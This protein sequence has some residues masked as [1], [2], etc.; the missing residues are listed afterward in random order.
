MADTI[1]GFPFWT[2]IFDENGSQVKP[3]SVDRLKNDLKS[4]EISELFIFSH[5][6]NNDQQTARTL[7][8][9]C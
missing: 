3:E 7:P 1:A 2:L 5:G 4:K 6:W 8:G 9:K